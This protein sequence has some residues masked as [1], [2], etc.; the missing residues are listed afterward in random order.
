MRST[1]LYL[2]FLLVIRYTLPMLILL[3]FLRSPD[4]AQR[5]SRAISALRRPT[6]FKRFSA[7]YLAF[8]PMAGALLL[9][10]CAVP[11]HTSSASPS[12]SAP[13]IASATLPAAEPPPVTNAVSATNPSSTETLPHSQ[14]EATPITTPLPPSPNQDFPSAPSELL[15]TSEQPINLA[16]YRRQ[17]RERIMQTERASFEAAD[18]AAHAS[19]V[20]PRLTRF[21][22]LRIPAGALL[23]VQ[24]P[25]LPWNQRFAANKQGVEVASVVTFAAEVHPRTTSHPDVLL[26]QDW[27]PV[28]VRCGYDKGR[29]LA[30]ELLD[31]SEQR[32]DEPA[33]GPA[34]KKKVSKKNSKKV[35]K[36][37]SKKSAATKNSASKAKTTK[38]APAKKPKH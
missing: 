24:A 16:Q 33:L 14:A 36:K 22:A 17:T 3:H 27:R 11:S 7:Q 12:G 30:Y 25:V 6:C 35:G 8:L 13:W 4:S 37:T 15:F 32:I 10:A 29:M 28:R 23:P 1:R 26:N 20:V 5:G 21:N 34:P 19:W 18:C 38:K 9:N 2:G 31:D